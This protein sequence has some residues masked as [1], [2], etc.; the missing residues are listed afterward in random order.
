MALSGRCSGFAG[1]EVEAEA[2]DGA[3]ADEGAGGAEEVVW[4][5]APTPSKVAADSTAQIAA[6]R[7]KVAVLS[8]NSR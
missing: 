7:L 4:A 8:R 5:D 3:A 6:R 1:V 2:V